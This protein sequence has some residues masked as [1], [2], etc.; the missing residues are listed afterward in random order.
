MQT[1]SVKESI[2]D[3]VSQWKIPS[4]EYETYIEVYDRYQKAFEKISAAH[5]EV[6][7]A[8]AALN[9]TKSLTERLNVSIKKRDA[10]KKTYAKEVKMRSIEDELKRETSG[11]GGYEGKYTK[12]GVYETE[13]KSII[14]KYETMKATYISEK[15]S[16]LASK[17]EKSEKDL[18]EF[19]R[20]KTDYI[21]QKK[22]EICPGCEE[23]IAAKQKEVKDYLSYNSHIK[24]SASAINIM[25]VIQNE[26][27]D[28]SK[29]SSS[30][31]DVLSRVIKLKGTDQYARSN[32][33][34]AKDLH[35]HSVKG[36]I[37]PFLGGLG[38]AMI[39]CFIFL[40]SPF[41]AL[42]SASSIAGT[43]QLVLQFLVNIILALLGGGLFCGLICAIFA[44][45]GMD[46]IGLVIGVIGG[47]YM[48]WKIFTDMHPVITV[49]SL[50]GAGNVLHN[51]IIW[52]LQIIIIL[53][54][55]FLVWLI[56]INTPL[57]NIFYK[58]IDDI[59]LSDLEKYERYFN[60]NK[61][62]FIALFNIDLAM[63]Y[64]CEYR[65]NQELHTIRK[66]VTNIKHEQDY[67][68]IENRMQ[69]E[70]KALEN[71]RASER[72]KD[73]QI[74]REN[75]NIVS[76]KRKELEE[77]EK[78]RVLGVQK[79]M[80]LLENN[81]EKDKNT[82][83]AQVK[84]ATGYDY[85]DPK[86][87]PI[88]I[89]E[90][91]VKKKEVY[92]KE[93]IKKTEDDKNYLSVSTEKLMKPIDFSQVDC[94]RSVYKTNAKLSD[95]IYFIKLQ[96]D[97][98]NMAI[99]NKVKLNCVPIIGLYD[100]KELQSD[101]L[102]DELSHFIEWLCVSVRRVTARSIMDKTTVVDTVSGN[103]VL[104]TGK[105]KGFL[106]IQDNMSGIHSLTESLIEKEKAMI[107]RGPSL[108][109]QAEELHITENLGDLGNIDDFNKAT[110]LIGEEEILEDRPVEGED[111]LLEKPVKYSFIIFIIP[112]ALQKTAGKSILTEELKKCLTSCTR[113]GI[114]PIFLVDSNNWEHPEMSDDISWIRGLREKMIWKISNVGKDRRELLE[115]LSV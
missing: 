86:F 82:L 7:K 101:N 10:Y 91:F 112:S 13:R 36:S 28:Q 57:I 50:M 38:L 96:K 102:S 58:P 8:K 12:S 74:R 99:I 67:I 22:E 106:N 27:P 64:A 72:F 25:S 3:W 26:K 37:F 47:L 76:K 11:L 115:I 114:V 68:S 88:E 16:E 33:V 9:E 5:D 23:V 77:A 98:N 35:A 62:S 109:S 94:T 75:E 69:D 105:F 49:S 95:Y 81:V 44:F 61:D 45:F 90:K 66:A 15:R 29:C 21:K 97:Q 2:P 110:M 54:V 34:T 1:K 83:A 93:L 24:K 80:I 71:E 6:V 79:T 14:D 108:Y 20:D 18:A 60:Y 84:K 70:L 107:K 53:I 65:I 85:C 111:G 56:S 41:D 55:L 42:M 48:G 89:I 31:K 46:I 113:G 73:E 43:T 78:N 39:L 59:V 17:E 103:S 32:K 104:K 19:K 63:E 92:E 4:E 100:Y 51:I 52:I 40:I 30:E 87:S